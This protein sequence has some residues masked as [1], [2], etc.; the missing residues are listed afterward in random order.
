M[1]VS[2]IKAV[3]AGLNNKCGK[4]FEEWM[5]ESCYFTTIS[6]GEWTCEANAEKNGKWEVW[7]VERG[8]KL[9]VAVFIIAGLM[10]QGSTGTGFAM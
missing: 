8:N 4:P 2:V 9:P 6:S 7:I 1:K 3:V 10:Q 5:H